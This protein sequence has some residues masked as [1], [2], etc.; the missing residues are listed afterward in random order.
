MSDFYS[1]LGVDKSASQDDIK[2]VYRELAL[3]YHP[4]RNSDNPDAE[5][6]FKEASEAYEVLSDPEKRKQYD[7]GGTR[8]F[9]TFADNPHDIFE[10][11]F[12]DFGFESFFSGHSQPDSGPQVG[13]D[14][15]ILVTISLESAFSGIE[16]QTTYNSLIICDKCSGAGIR[17]PS[18]VQTCPNCNGSGKMHHTAAFLNISMTCGHCQ[19]SG[20]TIKNP[21]KSCKGLG[22][23]QEPRAIK[24]NIP[25]GIMSGER[26]RIQNLGNHHPASN[27]PGDLYIRVDVV[28]HPKFEREM[29]D[30]HCRKHISYPLAVLG[31]TVTVETL[32]GEVSLKVTPGTQHGTVVKL[33]GKGMKREGVIGDQMVH[34]CLEV[35]TEITKQERDLILDLKKIQ[36]EQ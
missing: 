30:L 5:A 17:D 3:K 34:L 21:C 2:K 29:N 11:F 1:V 32:S 31:G 20:S 10:S 12:K 19:G 25:V 36:K 14:V 16:K 24:F 35:P 9:T 22:R 7:L 23:V 4:D 15:E 13:E 26:L 18:D 6:K 28:P 27:Q 8:N 33:S